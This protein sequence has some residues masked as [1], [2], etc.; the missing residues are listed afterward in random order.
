MKLS[1]DSLHE[2]DGFAL[3]WQTVTEDVRRGT[4]LAHRLGRQ[5]FGGRTGPWQQVV[6]CACR[7]TDGLEP[8]R[9]QGVERAGELQPTQCALVLQPQGRPRLRTQRILPQHAAPPSRQRA[10]RRSCLRGR[11]RR[12]RE[13]ALPGLKNAFDVPAHR[14]HGGDRYPRPYRGRDVGHQ[15]VPGP[16]GAM[17][18]G[19]GGAFVLRVL[20]GHAAA[21]MDACR[22]PP[23]GPET[24]G[25]TC[26]RAEE[27]RCFEAEAVRRHGPE[28]CLQRHRGP[29]A[30]NRVIKGGLMME[31]T[32]KSRASWRKAGQGFDL[33]IASSKE[34]YYAFSRQRH[35]RGDITLVGEVPGRQRQMVQQTACIIPDSLHRG[36]GF[37][38]TPARTGHRRVE[39]V[40][41]CKASAVS[42]IPFMQGSK[43]PRIP[44]WGERWECGEDLSEHVLEKGQGF[45]VH[46][47][48]HGFGRDRPGL[49]PW[50]ALRRQVGQGRLALTPS[51]NRHEGQQECPRDLR[52]ALDKTG[53]PGGGF[54]VGGGKKVCEHGYRTACTSRQSSLLRLVLRGL[55]PT[56]KAGGFMGA[57]KARN[58]KCSANSV[59][60]SFPP[61]S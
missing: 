21:G 36:A 16:Q 58:T 40:R 51:P 39:V 38:G 1:A 46:A 13:R 4:S 41:E 44:D 26:C 28:G 33:T 54:E 17:S 6:Q 19:G 55:L 29:M 52:R 23:Y 5:P 42:H 43:Q 60:T 30:R 10:Y 34:K 48:M 59:G 57:D 47:L 32:A 27:E 11:E 25:D 37:R 22:G 7:R 56:A 12:Q 15:E 53:T 3:V 31:A 9:R 18:W 45:L 14:V 35:D 50:G 20:A 24:R 2:D 61:P 49:A 8:A